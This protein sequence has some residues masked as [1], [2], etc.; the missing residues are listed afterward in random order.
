MERVISLIRFLS[1][2]SLFQVLFSCSEEFLIKEPYGAAA[3][4]VMETPE[5]IESVLAAAY[6]AMKGR[7]IF[8]SSMGTDWIYGSVA[9]DD[10]YIGT[11]ASGTGY[12]FEIE[13]WDYYP[14]NPYFRERWRDCYNGVAM[15]NLVLDLL[16]ANRN[17][18]RPIPESR[19]REIE[20]EAKFL[21]AWF[22]FQANKIFERIPYIKT[23]TELGDI[24]PEKIPNLSPCW[25]EIESDL[26]DA[27]NLLP[28]TRPKGEVGRIHRYAA[29]AAK[30]QAHMYQN[31]FAEARPLLDDILNS[32]QFS[33][34]DEYGWNYDM[35]HENNSESVFELQCSTTPTG[36]TSMLLAVAVKHLYGPA[37][38]GGWGFFQPTQSLFE[39]FQVG[40]D[41]LPVLDPALRDSLATDMGLQSKDEFHPTEHLLDPRVDYTIARRGIDFKG[42]GI[43]PGFDWIRYQKFGGP[44]M[45]KKFMQ[46]KSEHPLCL[47]GI[48]AYTGINFRLYR[49]SHI[50]LWRAE[51][52]VED[53][54]LDYARR[55]VNMI[56][57]R[58]KRTTPIMGLCMSYANLG[59]NPVVDW[60]K[61]AANYKVEP[62]PEGHPAFS[63]KEEARKAVREEIR[64]EFA[65]EGHRFF[66]LRRWGIIKQVLDD[67]VKRDRK[68]RYTT[69]VWY[70]RGVVFDPEQDD[71][72][73]LPQDQ[74]DLQKGVLKQDSSYIKKP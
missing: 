54:Q 12:S 63:S 30:A 39:A 65:T 59:V 50:I 70:W 55:L 15:A 51:V 69:D 1:Y 27:I 22:H 14:G 43:H 16:R 3:G 62:Y 18:S 2:L 74:V 60:N 68:F 56:R 67:F 25:D 32:G 42:W 8:G 29:E 17:S 31:E 4:S 71:Y 5:G 36:H 24:K 19:A 64:L 72:W 13:R 26:Q 40:D 45:T 48:G 11:E 44:Y 35:T 61:P 46:L 53:G 66:D 10:C 20:G 38:C 23:Q 21:R 9:S 73:P 52:A 49:L 57:E 47:Y 33:L 34:A 7:S 58:A 41:G 6:Q 37:S 28:V